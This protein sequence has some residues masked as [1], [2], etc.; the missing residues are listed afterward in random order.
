MVKK[1]IMNPDL[2]K[3]SGPDCIPEVV[4]KSCELEL[5]YILAEI[6]NKCLKKSYFPDCWKVSLVVSVFKNVGDWSTAK[7]YHPVSL[8]F[9][10]SKIFEKLMNNRIVDLLEKCGLFSDFLK[11]LLKQLQIFLQL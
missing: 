5:S 9:V 11:G 8:L 10:V 1:V 4:L 7:E 3:L 6:F 2:S